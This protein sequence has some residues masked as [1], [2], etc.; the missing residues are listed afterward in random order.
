M[1]AYCTCCPL[2]D[3]MNKSENCGSKAF[4]VEVVEVEAEVAAV[5]RVGAS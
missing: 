3:T 4:G 1:R 5:G 2:Y